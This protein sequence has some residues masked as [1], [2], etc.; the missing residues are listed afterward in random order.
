MTPYWYLVPVGIET[1]LSNDWVDLLYCWFAVSLPGV[2][3]SVLKLINFAE[4]DLYVSG[5]TC[6]CAESVI[7]N[8]NTCKRSG[9]TRTNWC[10]AVNIDVFY[11]IHVLNLHQSCMG[12]SS[13]RS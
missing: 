4:W 6:K 3:K 9:T 7:F 11:E 1:K 10:Y 12:K 8:K 2:P 5:C 13:Y